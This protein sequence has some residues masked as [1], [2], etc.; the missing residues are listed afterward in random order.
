MCCMNAHC[1]MHHARRIGFVQGV[2]SAKMQCV[3][4][5]NRNALFCD[6]D[7]D[8]GD[9]EEASGEVEVDEE[10]S[11]EE[12][13][14]GGIADAWEDEEGEGAETHETNFEKKAKKRA[15]ADARDRKLADAEAEAMLQTN[16]A[17]VRTSL[18]LRLPAMHS[19]GRPC[20]YMLTACVCQ[21]TRSL[22]CS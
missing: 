18:Q 13:A 4:T 19:C 6:L 15:Q 7:D 21:L 16:V 20:M 14:S 9:E 8:E 22:A 10:S 2:R 5:K 12:A 1:N 11:D 17:D 3:S